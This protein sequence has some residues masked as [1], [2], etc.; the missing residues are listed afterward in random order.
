MSK[1]TTFL[2]KNV[3]NLAIF[4]LSL[5]RIRMITMDN[6]KVATKKYNCKECNYTTSKKSDYDKHI[7]TAKHK[8]ITMDLKKSPKSLQQ[9]LECECGKRYKHH[10]GLSRHKKQC[11]V[12]LNIEENVGGEENV[13]GEG[14]NM[15]VKEDN[16]V[17]KDLLMDAMKTMK[18]Q[19]EQ[20]NKM[21]PLIGS[22]NNNTMTTNNFN[23]NLFLNETCK[24]ALN[25]TDFINSLQ[26]QLKDLEYTTDNGH[27]K[28]ITNIFQKALSNIEVN[29]RPMH[30][31]DL[32][33]EV[34]YIKDNNEW[35]IDDEKDRIKEAVDKV[36]NKNIS[37]TVKWL[38]KYP[39]HGDT[40][41]KDFEKYVKMSSNSMGTGDELEQKK[42]VKN[43]LKEITI[44]KM[45]TC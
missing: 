24:D 26:V 27:V 7:L 15:L 31:T 36:A 20:I 23:L 19:Q 3:Y 14:G 33:R 41:S 21:I 13:E 1:K 30:C 22:N 34:L 40:G 45:N 2:K 35:Q 28:G 17:Y 5:F 39:E 6:K 12:I 10:S 18:D 25:L 32:K 43:I 11:T 8:K 37:N 9:I 38:E 44:D 42:I 4:M 16:N 29:K